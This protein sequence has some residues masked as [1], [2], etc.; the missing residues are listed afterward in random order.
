MTTLLGRASAAR[1]L[2]NPLAKRG[3]P[4]TTAAGD[5]FVTVVSTAAAAGGSSPPLLSGASCFAT[6]SLTC[7]AFLPN[8]GASCLGE[9]AGGSAAAERAASQSWCRARCTA[10]SEYLHARAVNVVTGTKLIHTGMLP[11]AAAPRNSRAGR[12]DT[13]E[14]SHA[15]APVMKQRPRCALRHA[16]KSAT[17]S[18]AP[19]GSRALLS[20]HSR[21]TLPPL[22]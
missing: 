11:P 4:S 8:T 6:T 17:L 13:P 9:A 21:A 18:A 3:P 1:N 22:R 10:G 14:R 16:V 5:A 19:A 2:L 7:D 20:L 12:P 15:A